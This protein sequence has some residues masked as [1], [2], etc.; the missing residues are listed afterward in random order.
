MAATGV[1]AAIPCH[2]S[3]TAV[4]VSRMAP[5][6]GATITGTI[7]A[8]FAWITNVVTVANVRG[9]QIGREHKQT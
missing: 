8:V 7:V 1:T 9:W 5:R 4:P 6:L 3:V 2:V